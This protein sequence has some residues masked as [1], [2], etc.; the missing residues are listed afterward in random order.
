[1]VRPAALVAVAVSMLA[2]GCFSPN[3]QEPTQPSALD[4]LHQMEREADAKP[5]CDA[6]YPISLADDPDAQR[7]VLAA[8]LGSDGETSLGREATLRAEVWAD[9]QPV[10]FAANVTMHIDASDIRLHDDGLVPDDIAGDGRYAASFLPTEPAAYGLTMHVTLGQATCSRSVQVGAYT[11]YG[12]WRAS[13][14]SLLLAQPS[15]LDSLLATDYE[16]T[17]HC[18]SRLGNRT[19]TGEM[20]SAHTLAVAMAALDTCRKIVTVASWD[21]KSAA[22]LVRT[23]PAVQAEG[24]GD[25]RLMSARDRRNHHV[26][27]RAPEDA[28]FQFPGARDGDAGATAFLL[29]ATGLAE[30]PNRT[31]AVAT[32]DLPVTPASVVAHVLAHQATAQ[33]SARWELMWGSAMTERTVEFPDAKATVRLFADG[34]A[35]VFLQSFGNVTVPPI[36]ANATLMQ[37]AA[38]AANP[39]GGFSFDSFT[40]GRVRDSD[41]RSC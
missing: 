5:M 28:G 19:A 10:P 41:L 1:M 36:A 12:E 35:S 11:F 13:C 39:N 30:L 15:V 38:R 8:G 9:G 16:N 6:G 3:H 37:E 14:A 7:K 22:K 29:E 2:A 26:I 17:M 21:D 33:A 32:S 18:F 27:T 23:D 24:S 4:L 20:W 25:L 34:K 40:V 31:A